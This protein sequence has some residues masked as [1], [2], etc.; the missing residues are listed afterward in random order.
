MTTYTTS[1][2]NYYSKPGTVQTITPPPVSKSPNP[3]GVT[4]YQKIQA[5]QSSGGSGVVTIILTLGLLLLCGGIFFIAG[6]RLGPF[7]SNTIEAPVLQPFPEYTNIDTLEVN[8]TATPDSAIDIYANGAKVSETRS[9][10]DG[11]FI[12]QFKIQEEKAYSVNATVV[13]ST[14]LRFRSPFSNTAQTTY[15]KTP[16]QVTVTKP[17]TSVNTGTYTLTGR[18]SERGKVTVDVKGIK[19]TINTS[20]DGTFST[21]V[22][23]NA[24]E[25]EISVSAID[26]A[27][28]SS[29]VE[30]VTIAYAIPSI[31]SG[32]SITATPS[33]LPN[34]SG[35]LAGA[36]QTIFGN[37]MLIAFAAMGLLTY[38]ASTAGM[39]LF[40]QFNA[41]KS[42]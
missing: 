4:S 15:D 20:L 13:R 9:D 14:V 19:S 36:F 38:A 39:W 26:N 21:P 22:K 32:V 16:P 30:K 12:A 17:T 29:R 10:K 24:G 8:G 6:S 25:N 37:Y 18:V 23:L 33:V 2:L 27:N 28:N 3:P 7:E 31:T 35:S 41:G 1:Q 40:K 34:S 11:K 42:L 5:P